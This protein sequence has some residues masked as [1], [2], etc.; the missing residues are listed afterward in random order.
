MP[1]LLAIFGRAA[2]WPR[3]PV[4]GQEQTGWWGRAASRVVERPKRTLII[5]LLVFGGLALGM[6]G[7]AAAGFGNNPAPSGSDSA[8]ADR[9]LAAHF[10]IA[11][12]NPTNIVFKLPRSAWTD[13]RPV[14]KAQALLSEQQPFTSILGGLAPQ[15]T[16]LPADLITKLYPRLGP[17]QKL[18]PEMTAPAG[19]SP[20][21]FAAY[22]AMAQF[23][24]PD[25]RTIQYYAALRAGDPNGTKALRATPD[26]RR[27][28]DDV[29]SQ[30]GAVDRGVAGQATFAYDVNRTATSDLKRIIPIVLV[31]IGIL[32]AILLRSLIAPLY[33]IASVGLSYLASLGFAVIVFVWL[34]GEA[35]LN[36]VLAFFMFVFLMALGSDY[37]ILVMTRIREEAQRRPLRDAVRHAVAATGG[38]VTSAG[39]VLAGTFGV[40][41]A[42]G[43][44]QVREIG[45]GL[46]AGILLDTFLVR[47]LLLPSIVVLIGRWNW[48]PSKLS[49]LPE[50]PAVTDDVPIPVPETA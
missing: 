1:A 41:T 21:A 11:V 42:T 46:A 13:P 27:A 4:P 15:G 3:R 19:V 6:L 36:F 29:A 48:W 28:V 38:T 10:P 20:Q 17:P 8:K 33:L 40:L 25:G 5:G 9:I 18:P 26:M 30:I 12:R 39:L 31:I 35:G 45:L 22:R 7:Y 24:S 43:N 34:G 16:P 49:K 47:T 23:I 14:A 37:N 32:L 44:S 50:P 2:F